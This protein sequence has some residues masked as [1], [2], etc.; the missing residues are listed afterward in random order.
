VRSFQLFTGG[1]ARGRGPSWCTHERGGFE[2]DSG[3]GDD[4]QSQNIGASKSP[5]LN[6][7]D[8]ARTA[9]RRRTLVQRQEGRVGET[10]STS[11]RSS[12]SRRFLEG[13]HPINRYPHYMY[14]LF[15]PRLSWQEKKCYLADDYYSQDR[16]RKTSGCGRSW[17]PTSTAPRALPTGTLLWC[18]EWGPLA[19]LDA[20]VTPV[21]SG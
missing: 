4:G 2:K 10:A 3:A 13:L 17:R 6:A 12:P 20:G 1:G 14:R 9:P 5:G 7:Y 15:E 19:P 18:Y 16:G 21:W 8:C 11:S